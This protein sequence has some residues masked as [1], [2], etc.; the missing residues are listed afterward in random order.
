MGTRVHRIPAARLGRLPAGCSDVGLVD[1]AP[2]PVLARLEGLHDGVA[3][4]IGMRAG[5][6]ERGGVAATDVT[7]GQA[8][9]EMDPFRAQAQGLL[10]TLRGARRDRPGPRQMRIE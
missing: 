7:A 9:P 5:V 4:G 3:D 1:V 10:T 6:P 8:E 2:P